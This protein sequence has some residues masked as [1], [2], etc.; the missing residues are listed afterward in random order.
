MKKYKIQFLMLVL[1][2]FI[3]SCEE[4][5]DKE[6]PVIDIGIENAFPQNCDTLYFGE[7]FTF[8]VLFTDNV[9][10][11]SYNI[12]IHNNFD[13]HSHSTEVT[14]CSLDPVKEPENPFRFIQDFSIAD[15]LREYETNLSI[16]IPDGNSEGL[17]DE[18]DYHFLV[19]LVDKEGWTSQVGL[20]IKILRR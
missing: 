2:F 11:G 9:E 13:H 3:Y 17:F 10:L 19:N 8:K 7:A 15:G 14:E 20:S 6:N 1:M 4:E 16:N 12:D 5:G 18:G